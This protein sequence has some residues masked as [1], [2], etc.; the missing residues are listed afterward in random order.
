MK[1]L[2]SLLLLLFSF[3]ILSAQEQ[4]CDMC[5][6]WMGVQTVEITNTYKATTKYY[7]RCRKY[8]N[9]YTVQIKR[10]ITYFDFDEQ[11]EEEDG[12]YYYD[13]ANVKVLDNG[14]ITFTSSSKNSTYKLIWVNASIEFWVVDSKD[15]GFKP[16]KMITF[17][18]DNDDW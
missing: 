10:H 1:R 7:L 2:L 8:G 4:D 13:I 16:F 3:S 18:K 6:D 12:V 17:Y 11:K 14:N 5:G 9:S 15:E